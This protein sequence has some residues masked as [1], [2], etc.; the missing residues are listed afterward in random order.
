LVLLTAAPAVAA[1]GARVKRCHV[2][3]LTGRTVAAART[4]ARHAGC[5]LRIRGAKLQL[6]AV[7]TVRRQSP[8]AGHRSRVVTITIN[9]ECHTE[10]LPGP[11]S[12]EPLLT[13][14]ATELVS[15]IFLEGGPLVIYS[16]PGCVRH[17]PPETPR[18]GTITVTDPSTD[19]VVA[20]RTVAAGQLADI[21]LAPG[22]YAV[23]GSAGGLSALTTPVMVTIPAGFT[24]R[25][26]V[27]VPVP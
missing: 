26:D 6:A 20:T 9:P 18:A 13:A 19:A 1:S 14:G 12:G 4:S 22:A 17:D 7:Q 23:S 10:G 25:Q 16:T 5:R 15:G 3:K 11:P 2:P 8:P 21:P 27:T 24:V